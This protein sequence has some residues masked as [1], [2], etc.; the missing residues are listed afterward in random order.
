[1]VPA[2]A[3]LAQFPPRPLTQQQVQKATHRSIKD[4]AILK[5]GSEVQKKHSL[6]PQFSLQWRLKE[7]YA[8]VSSQSCEDSPNVNNEDGSNEDES[9]GLNSIGRSNK[10][11]RE[12][13][14]GTHVD[15]ASSSKGVRSKLVAMVASFIRFLQKWALAVLLAVGAAGLHMGSTQ[16]V[17]LRSQGETLASSPAVMMEGSHRVKS[18]DAITRHRSAAAAAIQAVHSSRLNPF[19]MQDHL[20]TVESHRSSNTRPLNSPVWISATTA[21]QRPQ[22]AMPR[23]PTHFASVS[24][25]AYPAAST[26]YKYLGLADLASVTLTFYFQQLM[27]SN[28]LVKILAVFLCGT[29]VVWLMSLLYCSASGTDLPHGLFKVYGVLYRAPG[30]KVTEETSWLAALVMNIVFLLGLFT[31]AVVLGII[32][33]EIKTQVR[34]VKLGNYPILAQS[35]TL[36]LGWNSAA[37]PLLRQMAIAKAR[38]PKPTVFDSLGLVG[39]KARK[40]ARVKLQPAFDGPVVILADHS[41]EA[42]DA[43][44]TSALRHQRH[45]QVLTREGAPHYLRDLEGVS[46]GQAR[47]VIILQPDTA[48]EPFKNTAATVMA[49]RTT[50]SNWHPSLQAADQNVVIQTAPEIR[51]VPDSALSGSEETHNNMDFLMLRVNTASDI[52][53]LMA[54]TAIQPGVANVYCS[55]VQQ[56]PGTA[57]LA[58]ADQTSLDVKGMTYRDA[59][60]SFEDGVVVG[61]IDRGHLRQA[62]LNPRD[63]Y[64]MQR[65]DRLV[66]LT[67]SEHM[68]RQPA[69]AFTTSEFIGVHPSIDLYDP[70]DDSPI[71][72]QPGAL[73]AS[74]GIFHSRREAK[75]ATPAE[76]TARTRGK[77]VVVVGWPGK[78]SDLTEGLSWF[79]PPGSQV[80]VISRGRPEDLP[81]QL[82]TCTFR[83]VEGST[84]TAASYA[85]ADVASADAVIIGDRQG[86]SSKEADAHLLFALIQVQEFLQ[87]NEVERRRPLHVVST[88]RHP[89]TL[90]VADH[91]VRDVGKGCITAELIDPDELVSGIITQVAANPDIGAVLSELV[92]TAQGHEIYLRRPEHLGI[93]LNTAVT[94]D[95]V[96]D[97]AR[98][99]GETAIGFIDESGNLN[100]APP[101]DCCQS[102][103]SH[104]HI[105]AIA[106][107]L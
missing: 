106:E 53:R 88:V 93:P 3:S 105:I 63:D 48:T 55:V 51:P 16:A 45:L 44:V 32:S 40:G 68:P 70:D 19:S 100:L 72:P 50:R 71:L 85:A 79:A 99:C 14:T 21:A 23:P 33:E 42:M 103:D 36:V 38:V 37:V 92:E 86:V 96:I 26:G 73:H 20:M 28:V 47:T 80:T 52:W 74:S 7:C 1:M 77:R 15:A 6:I 10:Y 34:D 25:G 13:K 31:F 11:T 4:S 101:R 12:F 57:S 17:R 2:I 87:N 35:H 43:A 54:Q 98:R 66:L 78:I 22:P 58:V 97:S 61:Y 94:F 18:A 95:E 9:N 46:A 8:G 59:R 104:S 39:P 81:E 29:P 67:S 83:H 60:H 41:K 5:Y 49:L 64:V 65:G 30:A 56:S 69:G 102:Y 84:T 27:L 107:Q 62:H 89:E 75:Q 90:V 76:N 82:G 24:Q 91:I